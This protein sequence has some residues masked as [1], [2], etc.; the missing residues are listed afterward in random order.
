MNV[1]FTACLDVSREEAPSE[2]V[3]VLKSKKIIVHFNNNEG[4]QYTQMLFKRS[5][6]MK[7]STVHISVQISSEKRQFLV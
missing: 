7:T 4:N 1:F 2:S 3:V 6:I 5:H